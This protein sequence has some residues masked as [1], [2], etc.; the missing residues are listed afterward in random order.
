VL[1][2]ISRYSDVCNGL[3]LAQLAQ[4]CPTEISHI[5]VP[6][7]PLQ[8]QWER[9]CASDTTRV[10]H[11]N[12]KRKRMGPAA[13]ASS[14]PR[15]NIDGAGNLPISPPA[16][17]D[18]TLHSN[19]HASIITEMG[20]PQAHEGNWKGGKCKAFLTAVEDTKMTLKWNMKATMPTTFTRASTS[21][22]LQTTN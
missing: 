2:N 11:E 19:L 21:T 14:I 20:W 4:F 13:Q 1:I 9:T 22:A 5:Q 16:A 18:R 8:L 3:N 7:S 15:V 12:A 10:E 6:I 17:W